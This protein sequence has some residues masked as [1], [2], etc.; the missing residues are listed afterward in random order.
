MN[1]YL[2]T[3]TGVLKLAFTHNHPIS[4]AHAISF[5]DSLEETK[6]AFYS[7]HMENLWEKQELWAHCFQST[8]LIRGNHTNNYAESGI[9]ILKDLIFGRVSV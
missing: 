2:I 6:Q 3:H 7:L 5:R 4:S 9:R 1:P 8:L